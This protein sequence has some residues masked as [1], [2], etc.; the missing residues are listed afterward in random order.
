[1]PENISGPQREELR[2]T[3]KELILGVLNKKKSPVT[4][5]DI[6]EG[7]SLTRDLGVDSLDIL[8]ISATV[9]KKYG[10]RIPEE[11]FKKMDD[12]GAILEAVA[13]HWPRKS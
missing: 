8:Q 9:E 1:M 12:L 7:V 10:L 4:L 13:R 6:E 5:K 3:V 11:E 2:K